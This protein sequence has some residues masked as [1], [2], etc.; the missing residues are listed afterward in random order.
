MQSCLKLRPGQKETKR[1]VGLER[2]WQC[3]TSCQSD[4]QSQA[5]KV[6][7]KIGRKGTKMKHLLLLILNLFLILTFNGCRKQPE[8]LHPEA[9]AIVIFSASSVF[10]RVRAEAVWGKDPQGR[11]GMTISMPFKTT[12]EEWVQSI[13]IPIV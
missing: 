6:E 7:A 1:L 3:Q 13:E 2:G 9:D 10:T 11:S 8:K 12:Y 5:L 4:F